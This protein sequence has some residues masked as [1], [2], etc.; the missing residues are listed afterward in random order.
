MF[1]ITPFTGL[2][3]DEELDLEHDDQTEAERIYWQQIAKLAVLAPADDNPKGT[4]AND[5]TLERDLLGQK[6]GAIGIFYPVTRQVTATDRPRTRQPPFPYCT[7]K[8]F[9]RTTRSE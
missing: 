2:P 8:G 7:P 6:D 9:R 4:M 3:D 1:K 5:Q